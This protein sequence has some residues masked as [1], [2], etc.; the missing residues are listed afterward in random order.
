M[1]PA[2]HVPQ[3]EVYQPMRLTDNFA[4]DGIDCAA[5]I[6]EVRPLIK[7]S[8]IDLPTKGPPAAH[9]PAIAESPT[10]FER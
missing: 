10:L 8:S 3:R 5:L 2:G 6:P 7:N 4:D 9:A 1:V